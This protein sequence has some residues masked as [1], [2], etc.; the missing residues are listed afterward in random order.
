MFPLIEKYKINDGKLINQ[1]IE[2]HSR[3]R[4]TENDQN[5]D[6]WTSTSLQ[7]S[8]RPTND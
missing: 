3:N 6:G 4:T 2:K 5:P 1:V 7:A 8:S